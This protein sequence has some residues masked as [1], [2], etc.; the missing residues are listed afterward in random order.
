M[1]N[2]WDDALRRELR[3]VRVRREL[4]MRILR[5]AERERF[6]RVQL[7]SAAMLAAAAAVIAV[8]GLVGGWMNLGGH[9]P[10]RRSLSHGGGWVWVGDS[11][12]LYHARKECGGQSDRVRMELKSAKAEGR[13]ACADCIS[14]PA[15]PMPTEPEEVR[16]EVLPTPMPTSWPYTPVPENAAMITPEPTENGA[17]SEEYV[18]Q[19]VLPT[20][21]PTP[22]E[23]AVAPDSTDW[24]YTP[25][26]ENAAMITPEPTESE[27]AS[28]DLPTPMPTVAP[29]K[30]W[31][32][33][34][35]EEAVGEVISENVGLLSMSDEIGP[36]SVYLTGRG[37]F[38]HLYEHCSGMQNAERMPLEAAQAME[39]P[40]CPV[41]VGEGELHLVTLRFDQSA[42]YLIVTAE[43]NESVAPIVGKKEMDPERIIERMS[44]SLSQFM[45]EKSAQMLVESMDLEKVGG[46]KRAELQLSGFPCIAE[47][48][49]NSGGVQSYTAIWRKPSEAPVEVLPLQLGLDER[50]AFLEDETMHESHRSE[51]VSLVTCCPSGENEYQLLLCES[52]GKSVA[53]ACEMILSEDSVEESLN[54]EDCSLT[55]LGLN[56]RD[57]WL[58][59]GEIPSVED[60]LVNVA[61]E[62]GL[63]AESLELVYMTS[64]G[65]D[66][67]LFRL[68]DDGPY[69]A[70]VD[71]DFVHRAR[72]CSG[73]MVATRYT[74]T[75]AKELERR[76]CPVCMGEE[77]VW[78]SGKDDEYHASTACGKGSLSLE[79]S[80][81]EAVRSGYGPCKRC[82]G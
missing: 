81:T 1:K 19:K 78:V 18:R 76:F 65:E 37:T 48:F 10:D 54:E 53:L 64:L 32:F 8:I 34:V 9:A 3:P 82:F 51:F 52:G 44:E 21:A 26:P 57:Y 46:Y 31:N 70:T 23:A 36:L 25:V 28:E 68:E 62:M 16:Y 30:E 45:D 7:R 60:D 38:Y 67:A 75:E 5:Q 74:R 61:E 40:A 77:R 43:M 33:G 42:N 50:W 15:T 29:E 4:K 39:R 72:N 69:W 55:Y 35:D 27:A 58:V 2:R 66:R 71:G 80:L 14:I 13:T 12:A 22:N 56:G 11:D 6:R 24:P 20:A 41:C 73:M 63:E 17:V 79:I 49:D 47:F 59:I